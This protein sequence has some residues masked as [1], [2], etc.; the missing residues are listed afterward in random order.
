MQALR[1]LVL[2]ALSYLHPGAKGAPVIGEAIAVTVSRDCVEPGALGSCALDAVALSVSAEE[3]GGLCLGRACKRGDQGRSASTFQVM[4]RTAQETERFELDL[5]AAAGRAYAV[6]RAGAAQCPEE[7]L[8][9]YCGGCGRRGAR[10]LARP[11]LEVARAVLALLRP[12]E[13][14][15]LF[16][17]AF[18]RMP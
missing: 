17:E 13:A 9:P 11:R 16:E 1:I 8:A 2:A 5:G 4:G 18:W 3:E 14:D 12:T 15:L 7:P 6:L 10:A